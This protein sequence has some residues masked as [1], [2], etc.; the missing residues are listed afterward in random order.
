MDRIT[1]DIRALEPIGERHSGSEGER[2]MAHAIKERLGPGSKA[3]M[4][5]FVAFTNR[6]L[7]L[8]A[9]AAGLLI[10][11]ILGLRVPLA[12]ALLCGAFTLSLWA[13][14][15]GRFSVFRRLAPKSP[16]YNLVVPG[17]R[18]DAVGTLV[19]GCPLDAPTW[20]PDTPKW[21]RRPLRA[22]AVAAVVVTSLLTLSA[23]AQPWGRPTQGMYLTA[24]VI[25]GITVGLG[26]LIRRRTTGVDEDVSGPAVM[27][28][29]IRR[30]ERDPLQNAEVWMVFTGCGH[31]YQNG[32]AAFLAMNRGR[33]PEPV[34]VVALDDPGRPPIRAVVS[35]GSLLAQHHRPTGPA[36]VERLRW[37]GV[38]IPSIDLAGE[39]DA[40][41]ALLADVRGLGIAGDPDSRPDPSTALQASAIIERLARMYD[42]DLAE[43]RR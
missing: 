10:S 21:L 33:M 15:T 35:E 9:H 30:F 20:R 6:E 34:L 42:Q 43:V 36:L 14:A 29:L 40:R 11:G 31:A 12:G 38:E 7:V 24:L 5:G 28:E 37:S 19:I 27:L 26:V 8:G 32:M 13:E 41:A 22:T 1:A 16:S 39:T 4:E 23:L 3:R 25:L 17:D 18:V 2:R